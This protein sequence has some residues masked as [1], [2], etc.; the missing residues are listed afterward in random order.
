[1]NDYNDYNKYTKEE[2]VNLFEQI[3]F[4]L[5][6]EIYY[7]RFKKDQNLYDTIIEKAMAQG[8]FDKFILEENEALLFAIEALRKEVKN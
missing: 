1:M 8:D 4:G 7:L 5:Y 6:N 3:E 2:L